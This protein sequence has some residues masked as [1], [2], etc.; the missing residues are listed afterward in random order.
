MNKKISMGA[1]I[2]IVAIVGLA[3]TGLIWWN[4]SSQSVNNQVSLNVPNN[5]AQSTNTTT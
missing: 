1:G 5:V 2:A 3:A 4:S